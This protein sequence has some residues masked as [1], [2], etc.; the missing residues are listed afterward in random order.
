MLIDVISDPQFTN[1]S[2]ALAML[3][4]LGHLIHPR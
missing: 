3:D 4:D 2:I 1:F